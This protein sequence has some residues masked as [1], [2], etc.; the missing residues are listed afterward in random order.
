MLEDGL[1]NYHIIVIKAG[2]SWLH[3]TSPPL[4]YICCVT[5]RRKISVIHMNIIVLKVGSEVAQSA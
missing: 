3:K 4:L 5:E 1:Y 2:N